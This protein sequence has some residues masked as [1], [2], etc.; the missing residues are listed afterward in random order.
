VTSW[1]GSGIGGSGLT[2]PG[3]AKIRPGSREW[4]RVGTEAW[5]ALAVTDN[6]VHAQAGSRPRRAAWWP[7]D[8]H[9]QQHAP[10]AKKR[11]RFFPYFSC[12]PDQRR[13]ATPSA[14]KTGAQ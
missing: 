4:R 2:P 12:T 13:T 10:R 7:Q 14:S 5:G 8:P 11:A 6:V 1:S 3:H 9:Q